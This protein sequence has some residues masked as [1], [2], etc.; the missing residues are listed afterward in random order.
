MYLFCLKVNFLGF[1][2][3]KAL[4]FKKILMQFGGNYLKIKNV[5]IIQHKIYKI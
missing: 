5:A 2:P 3:L 1:L 4:F